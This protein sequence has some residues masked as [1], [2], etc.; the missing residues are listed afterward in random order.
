MLAQDPAEARALARAEGV[1][2]GLVVVLDDE[3]RVVLDAGAAVER[4]DQV[5]DL[6]ARR[7]RQAKALVEEADPFDD[8]A[9]EED[10]E[11]DRAVP[12]VL[13]RQDCC[14]G[15]PRRRAPGHAVE[16]LVL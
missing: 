8:R 5:V 1:G 16:L 3:R 7:G 10:R 6:L 11:G 2:V 9:P 12:E 13:A 4:P 14:E 15:C